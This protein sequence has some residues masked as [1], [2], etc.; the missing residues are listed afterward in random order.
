MKWNTENRMAILEGRTAAAGRFRLQEMEAEG[1]DF[2][3][4]FG[5][6]V[7]SLADEHVQVLI[8]LHQRIVTYADDP[9]V[10]LSF[11]G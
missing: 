2:V 1:F 11:G 6:C 4:V 3:L 9:L 5:R 7:Q 8:L 10:F